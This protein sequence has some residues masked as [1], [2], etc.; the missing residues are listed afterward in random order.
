VEKGVPS[1][2]EGSQTSHAQDSAVADR[3]K[4]RRLD[5]NFTAKHVAETIGLKPENYLLLENRFG[6]DA[7]TLHLS[8][9]AR[10][11]DASEQWLCTGEGDPPGA[12]PESTFENTAMAGN[13]IPELR[14]R[15]GE[16]ARKRRK[17][18]GLKVNVVAEQIGV[19]A[20]RL[21]QMEMCLL[22][23]PDP[24]IESAWE[25]CLNVP[26]G[27]LRRL[28]EP[29]PDLIQPDLGG[30][31]HGV[32][33]PSYQ[34][35]EDR[36]KLAIRAKQRRRDLGLGATACAE[37]IGLTLPNFGANERHLRKFPDA[38]VERL[39]EV[40]LGVSAGWLRD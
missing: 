39:W 11:L 5:L 33:V 14:M 30:G 20:A 29:N 16:R 2:S 7:R 22:S 10:I 1:N 34:S 17:A 26:A 31:A 15:L 18:L 24:D 25:K 28:I 6:P 40:E 21:Y 23:I 32:P 12:P 9:L 8:N 27:W 36:V 3:V 19:V 4:T 38:E 35:L 13:Q 37:A